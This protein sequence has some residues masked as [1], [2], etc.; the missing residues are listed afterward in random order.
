MAFKGK[1]TATDLTKMYFFPILQMGELQLWGYV[2]AD[3]ATTVDGSNYITDQAFIDML[4]GREGDLVL[5]YQVASIAD[6][7]SIRADMRA[8]ITDISLHAVLDADGSYVDLSNDL[9]GA[10]VTYGD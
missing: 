10:T 1:A 5:A 9:L 4:E 8:G 2:S 7:R 6:T 3:A